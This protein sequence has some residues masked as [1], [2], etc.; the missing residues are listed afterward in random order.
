MEITTIIGIVLAVIICLVGLIMMLRKSDDAAPSLDSALHI[1]E[2]SNQPVIPRH[3]RDQLRSST[4][5]E[6]VEPNLTILEDVDVNASSTEKAEPKP[7]EAKQTEVKPT[8]TVTAEVTEENITA[9]IDQADDTTKL[10]IEKVEPTLDLQTASVVE[11]TETSNQE[12][13]TKTDTATSTYVTKPQVEAIEAF[14][15]NTQVETVKIQEFEDE[16]SILDVHLSEQQRQDDQSMKG[17]KG[18]F[19]GVISGMTKFFANFAFTKLL[20]HEKCS[21][22]FYCFCYGYESEL[23]M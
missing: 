2:D 12:D 13:I 1:N 14:T 3:V 17:N 23:R 19:S 11:K 22:T 15:P 4:E 7:T 18:I 10:K 21:K 8:E 20:S 6:R 9:H 5:T 16:S